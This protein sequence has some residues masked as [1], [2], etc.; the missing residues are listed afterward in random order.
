MKK[1]ITMKLRVLRYICET[2]TSIN[3]IKEGT[4]L[5][6]VA[7]RSL[8]GPKQNYKWWHRRIV[9]RTVVDSWHWPMHGKSIRRIKRQRDI[10]CRVTCNVTKERASEKKCVRKHKYTIVILSKLWKRRADSNN[11][12]KKWYKI[13]KSG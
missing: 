6:R 12:L 10:I 2:L 11:S 8:A 4:K 1:Y 5:M 13:V 9:S 3:T 7:P